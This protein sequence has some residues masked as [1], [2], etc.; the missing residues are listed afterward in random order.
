MVLL[1]AVLADEV[2]SV[3]RGYASCHYVV[4]ER[5]PEREMLYFTLSFS[6]HQ[7]WI[8]FLWLKIFHNE[9]KYISWKIDLIL[10]LVTV[11]FQ[12]S[13]GHEDPC[14][15]KGIPGFPCSLSGN[16]RSIHTF[17]FLFFLRISGISLQSFREYQEYPCT[18]SR[19]T[20]NVLAVFLGVLGI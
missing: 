6:F 16:S 1:N 9:K 18:V 12:Q 4:H 13:T 15:F 20:R 8:M 2:R 5:F 14:N 3:I 19:N 11:V 17:L 7:L 10:P